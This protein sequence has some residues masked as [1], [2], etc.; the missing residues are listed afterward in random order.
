M[1]I[2][3]LACK[4]HGW[5]LEFESFGLR[6]QVWVLVSNEEDEG[7]RICFSGVPLGD[8][9]MQY[10]EVILY[11]LIRCSGAMLLL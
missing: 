4:K 1:L 5:V 11:N 3:P 7:V 2:C 9:A 8:T 6:Q 10:F